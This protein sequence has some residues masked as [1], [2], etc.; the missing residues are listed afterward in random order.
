MVLEA[1]RG[2]QWHRAEAPLPNAVVYGELTDDIPQA[3]SVMGR[4]EGSK[5]S[6]STKTT[7]RK[8]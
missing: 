1:C 2:W 5:N 7:A 4:D 8:S 3:P 6:L